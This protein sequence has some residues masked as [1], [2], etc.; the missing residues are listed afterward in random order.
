MTGLL[1]RGRCEQAHSGRLPGRLPMIAA[2]TYRFPGIK[3]SR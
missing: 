1:L 2:F 3:R